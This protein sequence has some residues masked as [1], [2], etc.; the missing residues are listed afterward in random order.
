L[1]PAAQAIDVYSL[2][3]PSL[4]PRLAELEALLSSDE[5]ARA[6]RYRFDR[7]RRQFT[8]CRAWLRGLLGD[9]LAIPPGDVRFLAGEH[10]KP[11]IDGDL[12]FNLSHSGEWAVCAI[13]EGFPVGIDI[14][15]YRE[16]P[17]AEDIAGRYFTADE[18]I[19]LRSGAAGET[20]KRFLS[21]WTRKEAYI[22]AL[23]CGLFMELNQFTVGLDADFVPDGQGRRWG[24]RSLSIVPNHA[25]ALCALGNREWRLV[26]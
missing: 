4:S 3:W 19:L 5:R 15:A 16:L 8:I 14:E 13:A 9:R 2:H 17:A 18:Y 24:L 6:A 1:R 10:G 20:A 11:E 26:P 21:L 22:K 23:G 25:V 12:E 7:D